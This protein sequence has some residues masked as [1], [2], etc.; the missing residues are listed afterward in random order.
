MSS[1]LWELIKF[2]YGLKKR[3]TLKTKNS[4]A[5]SYSK[6]GIGLEKLDRNLYNPTPIYDSL[7]EIGMKWVRIQ[8]GWCR[9]ETQKGVYDFSWL[10]TIVDNLIKRNMK[11][12]LCLC[13]GNGLYTPEADNKY[14]AVGRPPVKTEAEK[15][16]W[17]NYV[18]ATVEHYKDKI[19]YFEIW[20]EPDG[21][22]C[23][24]HGV[25]A[26][27]YGEFAIGTAKIIRESAPKAKILAGSFF[28]E[29]SYVYDMLKTGLSDYIDYI[30]FHRYKY[31]PD[32]GN[33][34]FIKTLRATVNLFSDKIGIIQGETGTHSRYSK[35]GAL[36][37]GNWD[38]RK[39]AKFLLRKLMSDIGSGV[40]FT[41]YFTAVDIFEN[42]ISDSGTKTEEFYGF[43]GVLGEEFYE[44]GVPKGNYYKKQS[45]YAFQNLCAF[46]DGREILTDLPIY[47]YSDYANLVGGYEENPFND[48]SNIYIYGFSLGE[49]RALAYWK[50]TDI[51]TTDFESCCSAKAMGMPEGVHIIDLMDGTVYSLEDTVYSIE[52]GKVTLSHIPIKDYPML[53]V[54]GDIK[55]IIKEPQ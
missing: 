44:N 32:N 18:K 34:S 17:G 1:K 11:P 48:R 24:R 37:F 28:T 53:L 38:E 45:Y 6:L 19:D 42:I 22:H 8:S 13:Y 15:T 50:G 33:E 25:N 7:S 27:E 51:L 31:L 26:L 41:S 16:A 36:P 35:N 39:Q 47:F 43:F 21:E 2:M 14:G 52:D 54:F 55:K 20:N 9:T 40:E 10:D 12:W 5:E 49:V 29:I 4:D 3:G 46:F 30:T 23:W